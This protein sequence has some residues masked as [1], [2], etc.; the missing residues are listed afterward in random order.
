MLG[1]YDIDANSDDLRELAHQ[2][3]LEVDG[4]KL[5]RQLAADLRRAVEPA[6]RDAAASLMSMASTHAE[7][8][9]PLRAAVA[10][11]LTVNAR[12]T[13]RNVGVKVR[14]RKA[15]L[16]GFANAPKRLNNPN[17]WRHPVYGDREVWVHQVGK[18]EWFDR[19]IRDGRARYRVAV[20]RAMQASADRITRGK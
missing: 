10:S 6:K 15:R 16:R 11:G 14:S 20:E 12:V 1:A 8:E 2:V 13:G 19:P 4:R 7:A 17:G 3:G 18:P 5:Q 9:E